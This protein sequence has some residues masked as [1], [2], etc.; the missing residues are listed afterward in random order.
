MRVLVRGIGEEKH[1]FPPCNFRRLDSHVF[2]HF[3]FLQ[4]RAAGTHSGLYA[5]AS[6]AHRYAVAHI[7]PSADRETP[8]D[9]GTRAISGASSYS[10][11]GPCPHGDSRSHS[12]ATGDSGTPADFH[13]GADR[14][15]SSDIGTCAINGA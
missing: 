14:N 1:A 5:Y 15:I 8:S 4:R 6:R 11:R 12:Y 10:D 3:G 2:A 7:H 9:I 13:T